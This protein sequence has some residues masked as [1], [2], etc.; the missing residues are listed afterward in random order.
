MTDSGN[1]FALEEE[2]GKSMVKTFMQLRHIKKL[3]NGMEGQMLMHRL[4]MIGF[5]LLMKIK[6][7]K[8]SSLWTLSGSE[9]QMS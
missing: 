8:L 1:I 6:D 4:L 2:A 5:S 9:F 3:A 7:A